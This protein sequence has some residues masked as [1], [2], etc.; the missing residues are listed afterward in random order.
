[1]HLIDRGLA[2]V[3]RVVGLG[4]SVASATA[5]GHV[6]GHGDVPLMALV[7]LVGLAVSGAAVVSAR[8][9]SL[10]LLIP[11]VVISEAAGHW[12]LGRMSGHGSHAVHGTTHLE[13]QR[14]ALALYGHPVHPDL[15]GLTG[16]TWWPHL[17]LP[18]IGGHLLAAAVI[19]LLAWR[20]DRAMFA[21]EAALCRAISV[22]YGSG[23]QRPLNPPI[24]AHRS[25]R[26][27]DRR[28]VGQ[29]RLSH[30]PAWR[31][32]APPQACIA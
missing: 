18:M 3:L 12:L 24:S 11:F 31:L 19:A 13:T 22:L 6:L 8:Q 28:P 25:D 23:T 4:L 20:A 7:I 9:M 2:R 15:T 17:D 10:R 30:V 32:R 5:I 26:A 1:M 21:L 29:Q 27:R 14:G 16:D